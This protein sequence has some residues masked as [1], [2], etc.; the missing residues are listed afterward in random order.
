MKEVLSF[1]SAV[2]FPDS[3]FK[4]PSFSY[5]S[6]TKYESLKTFEFTL[7]ASINNKERVLVQAA[8]PL[9]SHSRALD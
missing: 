6:M 2:E 9:A 5:R 1:F 8:N 7:L 4:V 3:N